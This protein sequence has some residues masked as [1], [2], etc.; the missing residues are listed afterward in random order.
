MS[1][2]EM[3]RHGE[4]QKRLNEKYLC[5]T[6]DSGDDAPALQPEQEA[7]D[8]SCDD[9]PPDGGDCGAFETAG[10]GSSRLSEC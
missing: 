8:G 6:I 3:V 4:A 10:E 9:G 2:P 7:D 5:E 1:K